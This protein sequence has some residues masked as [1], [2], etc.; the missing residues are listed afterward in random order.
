[1]PNFQNAKIYTIRS[2][3]S[4][5]VYKDYR[6]YQNRKHTNVTSFKILEYGDAYIELLEEFPCGNKQ[7]LLAREGHHIRS[8]EC[9]NR[10]VAGR[11]KQQ[12]RQDNKVEIAA[13][14]KQRYQENKEEH[15]ALNKQYRQDN[16]VEILAK[17]KQYYQANKVEIL[18]KQKQYNQANKVEIAAK[19]NAKIKCSCGGS[20]QHKDRARHLR[21]R[22]HT[23]YLEIQYYFDIYGLI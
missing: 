1:M 23:N 11:T 19:R 5:E 22:K 2:H 14:G 20:Y 4:D 6:C 10:C 9:V 18:A 12:W 13:Y 3:H 7:Q 16:K 8:M 17:Q 15:L 21:T